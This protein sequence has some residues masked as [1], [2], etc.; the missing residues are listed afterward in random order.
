MVR[1]NWWKWAILEDCH[2]QEEGILGGAGALGMGL[3][4]GELSRLA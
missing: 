4:A 1:E 2:K 3:G